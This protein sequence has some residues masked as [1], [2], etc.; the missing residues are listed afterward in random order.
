M[1][2]SVECRYRTVSCGTSQVRARPSLV[3]RRSVGTV[4]FS[5]TTAH[6]VVYKHREKSK[7]AR[8]N[9]NLTSPS[10]RAKRLAR[11][12]FLASFSF[13]ELIPESDCYHCS[14]CLQANRVETPNICFYYSFLLKF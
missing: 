13:T 2:Q 8:Y 9:R 4:H 3:T 14:Q 7:K 10:L 12:D 11:V 6:Y 5:S 1:A